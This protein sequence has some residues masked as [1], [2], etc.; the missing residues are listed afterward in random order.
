MI[1]IPIHFCNLQKHPVPYL[2]YLRDI[3]YNRIFLVHQSQKHSMVC[4]KLAMSDRRQSQEECGG[5]HE[6]RLTLFA[7]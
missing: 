7:S 2:F 1:S 6:K 3:K 5:V 4:P